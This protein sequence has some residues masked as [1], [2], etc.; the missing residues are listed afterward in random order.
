MPDTEESNSWN[1]PLMA[2]AFECALIPLAA[3]L[4]T[5]VGHSPVQTIADGSAGW[6]DDGLAVLWGACATAPPVLGLWLMQRSSWRPF[7]ELRELVDRQIAPLFDRCSIVEFAILALIAGVGE[8]LLFRGLFQ[9]VVATWISE[10]SGREAGSFVPLA[11]SVILTSLLFGSL[12]ALSRTYFVLATL[13]SVYLGI[14]HW[15][16]GHVGAPIATHALYDFVAL[17]FFLRGTSTT[18]CPGPENSDA[19]QAST[20][21]G[22]QS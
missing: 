5:L 11:V 16:V 19:D 1:L 14:L 21:P 4:G 15:L 8:E 20:P 9:D 3:I 18:N 7:T 2:L 22:A 10:F 6:Y 17:A 13:M 12:H